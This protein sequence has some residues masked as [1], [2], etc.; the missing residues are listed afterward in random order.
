MKTPPTKAVPDLPPNFARNFIEGGWRRL[1]R[2][3]G[4]RDDVILSWMEQCGGIEHLRAERNRWMAEQMRVAR[5]K[6]GP[7]SVA[8]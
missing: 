7:R 1:E 3:Y 2:V 5:E 4:C 6:L 8:V